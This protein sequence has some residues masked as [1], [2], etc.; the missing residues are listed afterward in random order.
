MGG[1]LWWDIPGNGGGSRSDF[2][3]ETSGLIQIKLHEEHLC[4]FKQKVAPK[5]AVMS[6]TKS[7]T[8]AESLQ[9]PM[10]KGHWASHL[11]YTLYTQTCLSL[12]STG[13]RTGKLVVNHSF[14][15][16]PSSPLSKYGQISSRISV[17]LRLRIHGICSFNHPQVYHVFLQQIFP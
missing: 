6:L 10:P 9:L 12:A 7:Y 14:S 2:S 13:N 17:Y 15:G 11:S 3:A 16:K 5:E 1:G 8:V 4:A